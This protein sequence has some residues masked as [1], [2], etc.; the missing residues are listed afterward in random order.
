MPLYMSPNLGSCEAW[1]GR[2]EI[3]HSLEYERISTYKL[4]TC[5][6]KKNKQKRVF[7][8]IF[9]VVIPEGRLAGPCPPTLF[10]IWRWLIVNCSDSNMYNFYATS[11]HWPH[12]DV[13]SELNRCGYFRG[14]CWIEFCIITIEIRWINHE[15]W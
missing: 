15:K 11:P 2:P 1:K 13:W 9:V 3:N 8:K 14:F 4:V 6:K 12:G 7:L 10:F 5:H